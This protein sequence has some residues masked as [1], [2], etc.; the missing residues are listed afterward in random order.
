MEEFVFPFHFLL[1][2]F[3]ALSAARFVCTGNGQ[4]GF[5]GSGFLEIEQEQTEE[6][7]LSDFIPVL[8]VPAC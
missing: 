5:Y 3:C 4:I 7:E 1:F 6:T 8:P 2:C